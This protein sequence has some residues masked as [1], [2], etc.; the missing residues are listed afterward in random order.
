MDNRRHD[1][2]LAFVSLADNLPVE[3]AL[4]SANLSMPLS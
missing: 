4:V 2:P 1:A 3:S